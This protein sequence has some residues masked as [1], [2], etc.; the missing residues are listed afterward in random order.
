MIRNYCSI[1]IFCFIV[2]IASYNAFANKSPKIE[3]SVFDLIP[4]KKSTEDAKTAVKRPSLRLKKIAAKK[5]IQGIIAKQPLE[6][7]PLSKDSSRSTQ[8][9][10]ASNLESHLLLLSEKIG[11]CLR[12][13]QDDID[14]I[15]FSIARNG[16]ASVSDL[17]NICL[18]NLFESY[19]FPPHSK[20]ALKVSLPITVRGVYL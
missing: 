18:K 13:T 4:Q 14:Q 19:P 11:T 20:E 5:K 17:D 10:Y 2:Q 12:D 8:Q 9:E 7:S 1:L 16:E 15:Q 6:I 3:M